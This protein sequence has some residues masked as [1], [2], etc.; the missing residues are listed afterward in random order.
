MFRA[1]QS[2]VPQA[3]PLE[4]GVFER[5]VFDATK[6]TRQHEHHL[7]LADEL[8]AQS[9][10]WENGYG[11]VAGEDKE[12]LAQSI[13][14]IDTRINQHFLEHGVMLQPYQIDTRLRYELQ[15][16]PDNSALHNAVVLLE[17]L[18]AQED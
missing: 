6:Q 15:T 17:A 18:R 7:R 12:S 13:D 8:K 9:T 4:S 2:S 14:I 3:T 1:E 11:W 16:D 10:E 5:A